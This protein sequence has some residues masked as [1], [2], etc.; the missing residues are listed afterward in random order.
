MPLPVEVKALAKYQVWVRYS[1]DV[2]G[3]VDLS[4]FAGKGVFQA[5]DNDGLFDKVAI[6]EGGAVRWS[7][8]I[9]LCPDALYLKITQ[10][11]PEQLFPKMRE[12]AT[13]AGD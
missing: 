2:Q 11:R 10:Q 3:I 6:G 4:E 9:D 5:W 12:L 7:D 1:D 13:H 8:Q